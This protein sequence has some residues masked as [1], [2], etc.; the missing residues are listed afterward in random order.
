MLHYILLCED[1]LIHFLKFIIFPL[2]SR[3]FKSPFKQQKLQK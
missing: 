2:N 3:P 1:L